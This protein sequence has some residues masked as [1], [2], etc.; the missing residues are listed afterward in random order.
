MTGKLE[1]SGRRKRRRQDLALDLA[2]AFQFRLEHPLLLLHGRQV[3]AFHA[4]R[5]DVGDHGEQVQILRR[6]LAPQGRGIDTDE[7]QHPV[8][9]LKGHG[10]QRTYVLADDALAQSES[11]V[12]HGVADK[13]RGAPL[14]HAVADRR[15]DVENLAARGPDPQTGA[16]VQQEHAAGGVHRLETQTQRVVVK[17]RQALARHQPTPGPHEHAHRV[18]PVPAR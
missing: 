2:G 1:T 15:A 10:H 16:F 17:L 5:R 12:E 9:G 8:L 4:E 7:S 18:G 14:E 11:L 3:F 6:E 13:Q